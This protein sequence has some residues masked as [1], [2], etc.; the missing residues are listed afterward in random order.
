MFT[1]SRRHDCDR[2]VTW[3]AGALHY[4]DEVILVKELSDMATRKGELIAAVRGIEY[5]GKGTYTDCAI[6]QGLAELLRT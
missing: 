5:I 4:S 3:N 1:P 2:I 6:K